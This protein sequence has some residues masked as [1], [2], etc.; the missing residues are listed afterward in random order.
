MQ[1]D[2]FNYQI[3]IDC[4][5]LHQHSP[6]CC[7]YIWAISALLQAMHLIYNQHTRSTWVQSVNYTFKNENYILVKCIKNRPFGVCPFI[8]K[9]T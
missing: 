4:P 1:L 2:L 6:V 5:A 3:F 9:V 7:V 8:N